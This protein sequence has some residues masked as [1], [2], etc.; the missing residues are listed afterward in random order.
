MRKKQD[1]EEKIDEAGQEQQQELQSRKASSKT[2]T[3]SK[4]TSAQ[5][6][7][8]A[9]ETTQLLADTTNNNNNNDNKN[10]ARFLLSSQDIKEEEEDK[11]RQELQKAIGE[12]DWD[13]AAQLTA[14]LKTSK[15]INGSVS[16]SSSTN[17]DTQSLTNI[18]NNHIAASS[19]TRTRQ[20]AKRRT[21]NDNNNKVTKKDK[22][23]KNNQSSMYG[24]MAD[25]T[26]DVEQGLVDDDD[27]DNNNNNDNRGVV[28]DYA[29][30]PSFDNFVHLCDDKH[31]T[32]LPLDWHVIVADVAGSTAAIEAGRYRDVNTVGAMTIA[33]VR[34]ALQLPGI[35]DLPYCFGGDGASIIVQP[36]QLEPALSALL[37]LQRLVALNYQFHLR[38]GS[39]EIAELIQD[40]GVTVQVA[41]YEICSGLC[42][43]LFR[44]GGLALADAW[45]KQGGEAP[46][47]P[48]SLT[49]TPNLDGLSC[50]WQKIPNRHGC[51][52]AV[53]VMCNPDCATTK[54]QEKAI[55]EDV[56]ECFQSILDPESMTTDANPVN[57]E[58]A[59]Y[60][61]AKEMLDD[62]H[63]MHESKWTMAWINRFVEILLCHVLFYWRIL[64]HVIID[65]PAYMQG[66][67][68]HADHCKFDDMLRMVLDCTPQQATE[69]EDSLRVRYDHGRQV[70]YGTQ[71]SKHTLM[72]CL[73]EDTNQGK[74]IH[75]VDGDLGGYALA[76]KQLKWQLG[77]YQMG[78]RG[79]GGSGGSSRRG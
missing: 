44:G 76:A 47:N 18:P 39:V 16:S 77:T 11:R 48:V 14:S 66:M 53:L 25:H 69:I 28:V 23:N 78:K 1:E 52:L 59:I 55:Y 74:H 20:G 31:Y 3:T 40:G 30:L 21:K 15:T 17:V 27:D 10:N 71:R 24:S 63:R 50:R 73:L 72:T 2:A 13:L 49:V 34:N 57:P 19:S 56:L 22:N 37:A 35:A 58:L 36:H 68:S 60:K 9:D 8:T 67:R 38:I 65:A 26:R 62:E 12:S 42:I 33:V 29:S 4:H 41:R 45:I 32:E 7:A 6:D 70:F 5:G 43:A 51:V 79:G 75:F 61:T 46:Q 54:A 64:Q